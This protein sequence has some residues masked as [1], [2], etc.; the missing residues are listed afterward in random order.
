MTPD[1]DRFVA[2]RGEWTAMSIRLPDGRDT[3]AEAV[4]HR[5]RRLVQVSADVIGKPL[6]RCRVLDLACLEGHYGIEFAMHGAEVVGLEGRQVSV[7]KCNFVKDAYGLDRLQF[8]CDDV[9]NLSE[10]KYGTFDIVICSGLLYHLPASD[11]WGLIRA[12]HQCCT[13]IAFIDTFVSCR[14]HKRWT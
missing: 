11:A 9:R 1:L 8:A 3:R 14:A 2:E 10:Q 6:Q 12:M 5:L 4:D 13:G 7:D